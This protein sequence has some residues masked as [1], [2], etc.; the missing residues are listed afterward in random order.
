MTDSASPL[1]PTTFTSTTP[2]PSPPPSTTFLTTHSEKL[3]LNQYWYSSPTIATLVAEIES[4]SSRCAFLSTPSLF[5]SLT[6]PSLIASSR[7]FDFDQQW[8]DHPSFVPY[9]FHHP[10]DLPS[11][12]HHSFDF[13]VIDPPFITEDVWRLYAEAALLLLTPP[14]SYPPPRILLSSIPENLPLL[15]SLLDVHLVAYRPSIPTLIYQYSLFTNYPSTRLGQLNPEIDGEVE[16]QL[17]TARKKTTMV[18]FGSEQLREAEETSEQGGK[19]A[20]R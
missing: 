7:L 14:T 10:H 20:E 12:L 16:P 6:S 3:K 1:P 19:G 17:H 8:A 11:A 9:D 18:G 15:H 13:V 2:S 5:F 4:L